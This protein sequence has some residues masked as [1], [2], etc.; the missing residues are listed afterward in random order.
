MLDKTELVHLAIS[1]I[2][3]SLAFSLPF[4]ISF[5]LILVTVG[6]GFVAHEMAHKI[7][8]LRFGCIAVYR[9]WMEGLVLAIVFAIATSGRF[10]FAAPGAVYIFKP[11]LTKREN[12]L[13]SLAGPAMNLA[14]GLIFALLMLIPAFR[15][16]GMWGYKINFFLAFFNLIPIPPLDGSKVI[17][18]KPL[19]WLIVIG[20]AVAG[21]FFDQAFLGAIYSLV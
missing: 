12:G 1:V 18:W 6:L 5:P 8:A 2:T 13:I 11:N 10:V 7:V 3:I 21:F 9:A 15:T 4:F 14:L 20:I 19:V 17:T 16:V